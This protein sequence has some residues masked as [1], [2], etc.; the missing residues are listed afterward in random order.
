MEKESELIATWFIYTMQSVIT[1]IC[2][3]NADDPKEEL[4][5]HIEHLSDIARIARNAMKGSESQ[6]TARIISQICEATIELL[7]QL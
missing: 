1:S 6:T 4:Q 7:R 2:A 5:E 3:K